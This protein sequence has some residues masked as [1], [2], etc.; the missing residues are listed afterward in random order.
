MITFHTLYTRLCPLIFVL[1]SSDLVT[2][3]MQLFQLVLKTLLL[4]PKLLLLR[5]FLFGLL[6]CA[7]TH[8]HVG[9]GAA[10]VAG[11]RGGQVALLAT[12]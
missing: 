1:E 6:L 4:R 2:H 11:T 8:L 3:R 5:C 9:F 12:R 10:G 7:I